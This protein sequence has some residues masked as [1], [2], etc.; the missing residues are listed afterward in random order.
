MD[1]RNHQG[2]WKSEKE[3]EVQN[4]RKLRAHRW[5]YSFPQS[6]KT[7]HR[8]CFR[9]VGMALAMAEQEHE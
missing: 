6:A 1:A 7:E 8:A 9:L 5:Q 3:D 2:W 4:T